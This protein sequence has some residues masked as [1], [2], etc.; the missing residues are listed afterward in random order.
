MTEIDRPVQHGLNLWLP[1]KNPAQMPALLTLIQGAKQTRIFPQ[2][3]ALQDVHFARFLPSHDGATLWV[4]TTYDGRLDDYILD[5]V[6]VIG[7]V[8]TEVLQF[9]AD[10]PPLPVNRY[11][12]EFIA[13]VNDHNIAD[14][15]VWSAYPDATVLDIQRALERTT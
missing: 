8:F 11:P 12:R 7:D 9:I 2:L 13:F 5:F 4:I 14:A 1:L 6:A 15:K 10:A 3:L